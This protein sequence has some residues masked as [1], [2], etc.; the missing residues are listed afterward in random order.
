MKKILSII[1]IG[2][3]MAV[4]CNTTP[5][6]DETK[7]TSTPDTTGFAQF[8][9]WKAQNELPASQQ[10]TQ[11]SS[12]QP[13]RTVV[14]YV[15]RTT[16]SSSGTINSESSNTAKASSQKKGWSKAA[17]GAVIGGVGGAAAG[18]VINKKNR[19]A[20]AVIGGVLGAGAGYGIGRSKDKKDGRY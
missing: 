5:K 17:K 15:P 13:T 4:S 8:Q 16:R 1:T 10:M 19:A 18:A 11:N 7:V 9:Q 6:T 2:A 14:K 20:G 3:F 12:T